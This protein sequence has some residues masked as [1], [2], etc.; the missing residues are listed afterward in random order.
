M[1]R[2]GR[3]VK[4][5][6]RP[7]LIDRRTVVAIDSRLLGVSSPDPGRPQHKGE[8]GLAC[9]ERPRWVLSERLAHDDDMNHSPVAR[10]TAAT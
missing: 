10:F 2:C 5:D 9:G 1:Q 8:T 4:W 7:G 6:L 3:C